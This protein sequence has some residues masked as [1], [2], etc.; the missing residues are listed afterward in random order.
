MIK[1][2]ERENVKR[3]SSLGIIV[4]HSTDSFIDLDEIQTDIE[5]E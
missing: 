2:R 3:Q 5:A 1:V 4:I